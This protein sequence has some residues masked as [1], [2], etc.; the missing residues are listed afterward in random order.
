MT[1][2]TIK[3]SNEA[4]KLF[5]E[6]LAR[7]IDHYSKDY[8]INPFLIESW[9]KELK[10]F[11][12]NGANPLLCAADAF[13]VAEK[14]NDDSF[15]ET[16]LSYEGIDPSVNNNSLFL[17]AIYLSNYKLA[18]KLLTFNSVD[19]SVKDNL[20][21]EFALEDKNLEM[22][23]ILLKHPKVKSTLDYSHLID[24]FQEDSDVM[25]LIEKYVPKS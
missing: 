19:P 11:L 2:T 1:N 9:V 7:I 6:E 4:T 10:F 3:N 12:E 25:V 23:K 18:K 8:V 21:L 15:T 24:I 17:N 20:A 14:I 16:L 13:K 5:E 22:I